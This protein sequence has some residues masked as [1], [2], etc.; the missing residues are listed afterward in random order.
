MMSFSK[1]LLIGATAIKIPI[2]NEVIINGNSMGTGSD[3]ESY[4]GMCHS[5]SY[6]PP[7]SM[8]I[9]EK[10]QTV[11]VVGSE[12]KVVL[13]MRGRCEKYG[14][15]DYDVGACEPGTAADG[16]TISQEYTADHTIQSYE[17]EPCGGAMA[18]R[19]TL[20]GMETWQDHLP[21][22]PAD[23]TPDCKAQM[24]S[25]LNTYNAMMCARMEAGERDVYCQSCPE[26]QAVQAFWSDENHECKISFADGT[27][28]ETWQK[29]TAESGM[30][31]CMQGKMLRF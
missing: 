16:E 28:V 11:K 5:E 31:E 7:L 12:V 25:A 3:L 30:P 4:M 9:I 14:S 17:I 19:E 8:G 2:T 13:H 6:N 24:V 1:M 21:P 20:K 23:M 22:L 10:G 18:A 29:A 27:N 26:N 15:Y